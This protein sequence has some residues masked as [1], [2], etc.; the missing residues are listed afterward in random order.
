MKK[1]AADDF[2]HVFYQK[3]KNLYNW[4]DSLWLEVENIE[5]KEEIACFE[6]F[7][8]LSPCFQKAI[9]CRGVRKR[10]YEGLY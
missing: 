4:M 6:Q 5:A 9:C 10:L 3:M 8:L 7:I 2:E 1:S